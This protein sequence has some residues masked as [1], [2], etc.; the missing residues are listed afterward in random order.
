MYP[1]PNIHFIVDV[2]GSMRDLPQIVSG[3]YKA[4]SD[5]TVNGC[6]NP[7]LQAF[8]DG[9]GWD[10][11]FQ[12]PVPDAGT[13]LG[14]DVG[15]P[16]L[17]QDGKFKVFNTTT[18]YE[19]N[20]NFILWGRFLNFNP[21]KHVAL[22]AALK[23]VFKDLSGAR[24]GVSIFT[25]TSSNILKM[26]PSCPELSAD[27]AAF[28]SYRADF[29]TR[30]NSL[31]FN[32]A[33]PLARSL[34]NAGYYFSSG[35]DI[36]RDTFGFGVSSPIAYSYPIDFKSE[37]LTSENCTVCWGSQR[38]AVI[39]ISDGD[40]INDTLGFKAV[41]R[42]REINGGKVNCPSTA[43]CADAADDANHMLDDVAKLLS[44]NDLQRSAPL[45][46]ETWTPR[47]CR[48]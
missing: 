35:Q 30:L 25:A 28:A 39:L 45:S 26:K 4:F 2:S 12:Y 33:T 19:T 37:A 16:N 47:A 20:T 48:A 27:P 41:T 32:T 40:P 29:I 17:F 10:P 7:A 6:E 44:H 11:S 46:W 14:T 9:H 34:L 36:Y 43:P 22:R 8:S 24:A 18:D 13:G 23:K 3:Q 15:F 42:L 38:N 31:T 21:P 1:P 5:A